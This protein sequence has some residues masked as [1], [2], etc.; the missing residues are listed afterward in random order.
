MSR[1]AP[2]GAGA[3][4]VP[5][6]PD[7]TAP[8]TGH[9][10]PS[11]RCRVLLTV[12]IALYALLLGSL[13]WL[14]YATFHDTTFDLALYARMAWGLVRLEFWNPVVDAH[15]L[16]V[17]FSPVL[18]P[19]GLLGLL[20]GTVPVLLG[21]QA[22]ALALAAW[23]LALLA[24]RRLGDLGALAAA[25]GWMAYPN[26][27][28]VGTDEFHPGTLAVLPLAWAIEAADRGAG[29]ALLVACAGAMA[30][31]ED[32]GIVVAPLTLVAAAAR[33]ALRR[34]AVAMALGSAAWTALFVLLVVPA[35]APR[36]SSMALHFGKWGQGAAGVVLGLLSSPGRLLEHLMEPQRLAYLPAVLA[37]LAMLPV[38]APRWTLVAMPVLVANL[39]S[40][41]PDAAR[42]SSH[43]LTVAVAPLAAAAIEAA[44]RLSVGLGHCGPPLLTL[45]LA[46]AIAHALEGGTPLSW[47]FDP[48]SFSEDDRSRAAR[49]IVERIPADASVH[50]PYALMPHL[51]EREE[52]FKPVPPERRARF[53][54]L[55]L[56]H[57]RRW[58]HDETLLRTT[59]EP[60]ARDWLARRDHALVAAEGDFV[61]L[62]RGRPPRSGIVRRYLVESGTPDA[63][64]GVALSRC[65]RLIGTEPAGAWAMALTL[66]AVDRCPRD[67]AVRIGASWRPRR[68][69]LLFDGLLSP[70]LLEPG[71]VARSVHVLDASERAAYREG[72]LRVGLLRSSGARPEPCDPM[73]VPLPAP[74]AD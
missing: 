6:V 48:R 49:R 46:A 38:L 12:G 10:G 74:A 70:E 23:P 36:E 61:L 62:E 41:W 2:P 28:R 15:F 19:L 31:R 50:A 3:V 60:L 22:L 14:R 20:F 63:E 67:L 26:L 21:A 29:K 1:D 34:M 9:G 13:G 16:G 37:P 72:R 69:D 33:P 7:P 42:P 73:T 25:F 57:R 71:Q 39:L 52:I 27:S 45:V 64:R 55:D 53:V 17:H 5:A 4:M 24:G 32:L 56:W 65:L 40:D 54:V 44:G 35:F 18:L 30:C 68:V 66:R 47:A 59:E 51:A 8:S 58:A 43:Y 11:R